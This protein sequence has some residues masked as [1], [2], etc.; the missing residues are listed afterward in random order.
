MLQ[1][2]IKKQH[3]HS[4]ALHSEMAARLEAEATLGNQVV[5]V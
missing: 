3:A 2:S 4:M 5:I 1:F